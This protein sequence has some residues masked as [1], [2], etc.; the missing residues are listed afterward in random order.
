[1]KQNETVYDAGPKTNVPGYEGQSVVREKMLNPGE[2]AFF[3]SFALLAQIFIGFMSCLWLRK[4]QEVKLA[5]SIIM[6]MGF[7]G[8]VAGVLCTFFVEFVRLPFHDYMA[9]EDLVV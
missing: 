5:T 7:R 8:A 6:K 1:M 2:R 3:A 4:Q 9:E